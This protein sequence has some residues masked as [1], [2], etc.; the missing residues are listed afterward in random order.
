MHSPLRCALAATALLA[1]PRAGA[2][3]PV[4][5]V[6]TGDEIAGVGKV[7][8]IESVMV[9][10]AGWWVV[11]VATDNPAVPSVALREGVVFRKVGDPVPSLPG[12][13]LAGLGGWSE[14]GFGG[15]ANMA[16]LAGTPGGSTDDQAVLH[17]FGSVHLQTG[18]L[19]SLATPD[20]PPGSVWSSFGE[21]RFGHFTTDYALTGSVAQPGVPDS[22]RSF[23][24]IA[25]QYGSI[26]I[27]CMVDAIAQEGE[28]APGLSE[29]IQAVRTGPWNARMQSAG[30]WLY[31][32][33]DV[34]GSSASDGC[35]YRYATAGHSHEL[36]AREG[37][38]SPVAGRTWGPL[39]D[40]ALDAVGPHWTLRTFLDP[41]D[42]SSD[43]I[44]VRNGS[45]LAQEGDVL[46]AT[47]PFAIDDLGSGRGILDAAGRVL[48]YGRWNDPSQV[49]EAL[50]LDQDVLV[51]T[52]T[53]TVGGIPLAGLSS[54]PV[55]FDLSAAGNYVVFT[56]TRADGRQG[57]F[58]LNLGLVKGYCSAKPNSK[59]CLVFGSNSGAPSASSGS[60]FYLSAKGILSQV[61]GLLLYGT[62]GPAA[63]P[64]QH[65]LLC[66]E[67]PLRRLPPLS[68]GGRLPPGSTCNGV[69]V[70]DFNAWIASGADPALVPGTTVFT[71]FW[72][73]DPGYA[74]PGDFSLTQA[75]EFLI[76]P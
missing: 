32:G 56:G 4:L 16:R 51:R 73:R 6:G 61:E 58:A 45:K 48:W 8:R 69:L 42:P 3:S 39:E 47:A 44:L 17:S 66:V 20:F 40:Y 62:S 34:S 13:T 71:Q 18:V 52:G 36:L 28:V 22:E 37:A 21:A 31:W 30:A 5:L 1:A 59:G 24:A 35:V 23:L 60:P 33:C 54:G 50:F 70:V 38:A 41:S 7:T 64:L 65:A 72:A 53:T 26:G 25:M 75:H 15:L 11:Q 27:C 43:A 10:F 29:R 74:P 57:A 68:S 49:G 19:T 55:D 46:P 67:P 12:V 76:G 63:T 14:D 2:Q 9:D